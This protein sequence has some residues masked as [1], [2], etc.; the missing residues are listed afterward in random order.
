MLV[1]LWQD[2]GTCGDGIVS[3]E[4]VF[5]PSFLKI[6]E[7]VEKFLTVDRPSDGNTDLTIPDTYLSV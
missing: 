4:V 7:L 6:H 2:I 1:F 5:L 3:D